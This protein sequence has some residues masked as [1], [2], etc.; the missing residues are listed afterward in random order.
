MREREGNREGGREGKRESEREKDS[1]PG[2]LPRDGL[3]ALLILVLDLEHLPEVLPQ[4]VRRCPLP[5]R[6]M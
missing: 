3:V 4:V 6:Y 2:V 5:G 1:P